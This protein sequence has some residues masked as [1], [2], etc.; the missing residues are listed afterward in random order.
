MKKQ[1]YF[2]SFKKLCHNMWH[3]REIYR[4][5]STNK[6]KRKKLE[7]VI[8]RGYC[9]LE[10][11]QKR[12]NNYLIDCLMK[13]ENAEYL[14]ENQEEV[15]KQLR[16]KLETLEHTYRPLTSY[17]EGPA[18]VHNLSVRQLLRV[19][20]IMEALED[21]EFRDEIGKGLEAD[22]HDP[23]S[24]YGGL[25]VFENRVKL[26]E[27]ESEKASEKDP[28]NNGSYH[29][30]TTKVWGIPYLFEYHYHA[31]SDDC[32]FLAGPSHGIVTAATSLIGLSVKGDFVGSEISTIVFGEDHSIVITKL[33][34]NNFNI[35]YFGG[36]KKEDGQPNMTVLDLGNYNYN[37]TSPAAA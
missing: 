16:E 19:Y 13:R 27:V 20:L 23:Y 6:K 34:G 32:S 3:I 30:P 24:E 7:T 14:I 36:E 28:R 12:N 18:G 15:K 9:W 11:R 2:S 25:G 21:Q 29:L 35:D 26:M 5:N 33:K 10:R 31:T 4:I 8:H 1:K 37:K 22:L 17:T